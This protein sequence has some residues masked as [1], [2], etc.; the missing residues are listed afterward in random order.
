MDDKA[1]AP[2]DSVALSI[3]SDC[4]GLT[5]SV[6]PTYQDLLNRV[7]GPE[8]MNV[9]VQV[10]S[11]AKKFNETMTRVVS[12]P[13]SIKSSRKFIPSNDRFYLNERIKWCQISVAIPFV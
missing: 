6:F 1:F 11:N 3:N 10:F 7:P 4:H 2:Q 8:K 12:P 9:R 13:S 5:S